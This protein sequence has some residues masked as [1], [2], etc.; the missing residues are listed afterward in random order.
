MRRPNIIMAIAGRL[1]S[2]R[3]IILTLVNRSRDRT[4]PRAT[5]SLM[6]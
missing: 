1:L 5:Q 2:R 4:A 3:C 6:P